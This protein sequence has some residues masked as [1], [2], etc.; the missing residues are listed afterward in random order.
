[1]EALPL[2][3]GSRGSPA[4]WPPKA[5]SPLLLPPLGF[6]ALL[7]FECAAHDGHDGCG[8]LQ[9]LFGFCFF[10][11]GVTVGGEGAALLDGFQGG[12]VVHPGFFLGDVGG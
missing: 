5:Q 2:L 4:P 3:P 12:A 11:L 10:G 9:V 8:M 7:L 6:E 1:M